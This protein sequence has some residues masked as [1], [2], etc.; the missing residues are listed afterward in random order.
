MAAKAMGESRASAPVRRTT[1][2]APAEALHGGSPSIESVEGGGP[3]GGGD[4]GGGSAHEAAVEEEEDDDEGYSLDH[5]SAVIRPVG[6]TMV[7]AS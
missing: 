3:R 4:G 1:S 5:L 7:L 6:L 2:A